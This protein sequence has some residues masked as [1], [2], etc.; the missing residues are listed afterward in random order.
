MKARYNCVCCAVPKNMMRH[1]AEQS[2]DPAH[3][4]LL[5]DQV[6][7]T[8]HLRA[9]RATASSTPGSHEQGSKP[10]HRRIFDA[11]QETML[12]GQLLRDEGKPPSVDETAN[13]VY[14]NL[15]LALQFFSSVLGR[16]SADGAGMRV[17]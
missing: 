8:S 6:A 17:D 2:D 13:E 1:L 7:R 15:G 11:Q 14:D 3:R 5:L 16:N 4:Q 12:P 9:R 10:L